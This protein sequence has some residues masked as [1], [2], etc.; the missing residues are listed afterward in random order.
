MKTFKGHENFSKPLTLLMLLSEE[1]LAFT[2][3]SSQQRARPLER[4]SGQV[5]PFSQ[6]SATRL[7]STSI[8]Y[9]GLKK[10]TKLLV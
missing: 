6:C 7:G 8:Y 2:A 1:N 5:S 3:F 9:T 10:S 4:G